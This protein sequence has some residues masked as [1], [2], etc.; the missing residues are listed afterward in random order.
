MKKLE[1]RSLIC[2]LLIIAMMAGLVYFVVRLEMKGSEW[3]GFYANKHIFSNGVLK[4][5]EL[6]DRDGDT[7]LE[8]DSEGAHYTGDEY[9]RRA[10]SHVTG[11]IGNNISTGANVVFRSRLVG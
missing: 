6:R 1:G 7:L 10:V 9:Q 2:L 4:A 3:A 11:D 5:G 8:Y